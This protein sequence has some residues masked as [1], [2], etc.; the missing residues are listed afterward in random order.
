MCV[1]LKLLTIAQHLSKSMASK[2]LNILTKIST[3]VNQNRG[4]YI[5]LA[6]CDLEV[7][8]KKYLNFRKIEDRS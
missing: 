3:K 5:W 8:E 1:E 2:R 4:K 6:F 7:Y